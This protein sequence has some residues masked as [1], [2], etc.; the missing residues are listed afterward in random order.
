MV[1]A[2]LLDNK[3]NFVPY[4]ES[5]C[6]ISQEHN[7]FF[8]TVGPA[9]NCIF[10]AAVNTDGELKAN[11]LDGTMNIVIHCPPL[12]GD[13]I[14]LAGNFDV[15]GKIDGT[16]F[17]VK[18]GADLSMAT[19]AADNADISLVNVGLRSR[20]A[21]PLEPLDTSKHEVVFAEDLSDEEMIAESLEAVENI[22]KWLS[23]NF[24]IE[25]L[26]FD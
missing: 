24:G 2:G 7:T 22:Y 1:K 13:N 14:S 23:D 19:G 20:T 25:E 10:E 16:D 26:V 15:D 18:A 17:N 11:K 4:L 3:D 12:F 5:L 9:D 6:Y 8:L 21:K